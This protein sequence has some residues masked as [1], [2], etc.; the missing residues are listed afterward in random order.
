MGFCCT[1]ISTSWP[2]IFVLAHIEHDTAVFRIQQSSTFLWSVL[3]V[4]L[5][6]S[7]PLAL[8]HELVRLKL[9]AV[10]MGQPWLEATGSLHLDMAAAFI[11]LLCCISFALGVRC[12]GSELQAI[13]LCSSIMA[14]LVEVSWGEINR[15]VASLL[16]S[17]PECNGLVEGHN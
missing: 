3:Q 12:L 6:C 13:K 1:H 9:V 8:G 5:Y 10:H 2:T 4:S 14:K 15:A 16:L 7:I 17:P 11:P